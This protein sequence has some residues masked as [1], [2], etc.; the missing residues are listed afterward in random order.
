[1]ELTDSDLG[2]PSL[3][4]H[5]AARARPMTHPAHGVLACTHTAMQLAQTITFTRRLKQH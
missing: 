2:Q 1:M 5:A 4:V 3:T